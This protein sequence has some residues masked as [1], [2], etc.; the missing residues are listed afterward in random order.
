[1]EMDSVCQSTGKRLKRA[2]SSLESA[3]RNLLRKEY[4]M[5]RLFSVLIV[6]LFGSAA[7]AESMT[8]Q[9]KI[10]ALLAAVGSP[11]VTFVRNGEDWDGPKFKSHLEEK[12]KAANPPITTA[13]DFIARIASTSSKTGKPY[14]VKTKNGKKLKASVWLRARLA[15]LNQP[16]AGG[17][18]GT[19]K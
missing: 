19:N 11:D 13:D 3:P 12:L 10:D 16:A 14:L 9:Q 4:P 1:M 18:D 5:L 15:S 7:L 6:V 8:E 17:A 2:Y